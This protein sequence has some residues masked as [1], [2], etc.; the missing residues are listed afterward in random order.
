MGP[1]SLFD[2]RPNSLHSAVKNFKK[3]KKFLNIYMSLVMP[4][5]EGQTLTDRW[6]DRRTDIVN[7]GY[8]SINV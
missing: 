3:L 7:D 4:M 6:T 1:I 2:I 8:C 5:T